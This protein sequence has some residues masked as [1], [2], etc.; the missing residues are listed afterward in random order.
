MGDDLDTIKIILSLQPSPQ[1]KILVFNLAIMLLPFS[2]WGGVYVVVVV[3][4]AATA[5]MSLDVCGTL[6]GKARSCRS[7][8]AA[9]AIV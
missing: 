2:V 1:G 6:V 7:W 5:A 8:N 3:A 9:A 4:A